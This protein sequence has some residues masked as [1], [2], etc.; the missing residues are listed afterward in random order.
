M[1]HSEAALTALIAR[2]ED[3]IS[4]DTSI[5]RF[6]RK[7]FLASVA[8]AL[9]IPVAALG[10]ALVQAQR[11]RLCNLSR[12]DLVA[13]CDD[14]RDLVRASEVRD[15]SAEYHFYCPA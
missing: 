13:A 6:G 11:L 9:C 7:V 14:R 10:D 5:E 8:D 15:G 1:A 12:L 2:I 3:R 4:W